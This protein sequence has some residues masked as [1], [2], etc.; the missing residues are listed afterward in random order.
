MQAAKRK[1]HA[2]NCSQWVK[3]MGRGAL[4]CRENLNEK[5][6]VKHVTLRLQC[7]VY[8]VIESYLHS[9]AGGFVGVHFAA[10]ASF[11]CNDI[12]LRKL[13]LKTLAKR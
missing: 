7:F 5:F 12:K 11:V 8:S 13:F 10:L 4:H 2:S 1:L 9:G 3:D 6:L